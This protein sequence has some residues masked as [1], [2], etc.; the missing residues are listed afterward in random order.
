MS[1]ILAVFFVTAVAMLLIFD[2]AEWYGRYESRFARLGM[3]PGFDYSQHQ[4]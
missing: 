2:A 4:R 1:R 3:P